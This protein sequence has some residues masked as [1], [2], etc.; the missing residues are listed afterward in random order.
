MSPPMSLPSLELFQGMTGVEVD[1]ALELLV[2][3]NATATVTTECVDGGDG[4]GLAD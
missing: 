4:G 3:T 2:A 1:N